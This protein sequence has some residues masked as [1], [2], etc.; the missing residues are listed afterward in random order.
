MQTRFHAALLFVVFC[1]PDIVFAQ[2]EL[3]LDIHL[4]RQVNNAQTEQ[5]G[6]VEWIDRSSFPLFIAIPVGILLYGTLADDRS[7]LNSGVLIGVSQSVTLGATEL[8]KLIVGRE[9]PFEVL[10]NVK[11]KHQ[12]SAT[13]SSFPSGH[14]SQ[15]F[16]IATMLAFRAQP[17]VFIPALLWATFVGYGRIY[18]GVHYPTDVLG[19]L[20]L[21]A[22]VSAFVYSYRD[23]VL[24]TKDRFLNSEPVNAQR[25]NA[26]IVSVRIPFSLY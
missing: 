18:I 20:V 4:F 10:Q 9:R 13:G 14:T 3:G 12:S 17:A 1:L 15:A 2:E 6:L 16:A 23:D 24:K 8:T 5:D 26:P 11:L 21:G 7:V 22:A 19:G 25:M